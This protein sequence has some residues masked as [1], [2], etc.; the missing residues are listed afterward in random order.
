MAQQDQWEPDSNCVTWRESVME[1]R[2]D[3]HTESQVQ[4]NGS[5]KAS[6]LD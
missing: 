3:E 4:S 6:L 2:A 5:S 1:D